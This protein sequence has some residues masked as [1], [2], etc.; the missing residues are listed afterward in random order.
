MDDPRRWWSP[1][2]AAEAFAGVAIAFLVGAI[3]LN[4]AMRLLAEVWVPLAV[5]GAV[6]AVVCCAAVIAWRRWRRW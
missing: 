5:T 2:R 6:L 1:S 4:W 3:A